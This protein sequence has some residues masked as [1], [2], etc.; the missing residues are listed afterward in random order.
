MNPQ[1]RPEAALALLRTD[2]LFPIPLEVLNADQHGYQENELDLGSLCSLVIL[3]RGRFCSPG[4]IWQ[5][6][7]T[8]LVVTILRCNWHLVLE[9]RDASK[10]L[11]MHRTA[12]HNKESYSPKCLQLWDWETVFKPGLH[13][14]YSHDA[15]LPGVGEK[16]KWLPN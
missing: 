14:W 10:Y 6:L 7:Q 4:A 2:W 13:P 8:V 9:T 5:C 11:T 16:G 15:L 3:N 12:F 1:N